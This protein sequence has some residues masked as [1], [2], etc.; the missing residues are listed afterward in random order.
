MSLVL[1]CDATSAP[2]ALAANSLV[3]T[4]LDACTLNAPA[5]LSLTK[6]TCRG[7]RTL[8]SVHDAW[9]RGAV[10]GVDKFDRS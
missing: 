8:L 3:L 9:E 2:P 7:L 6:L 1:A 5:A 10:L 4:Y